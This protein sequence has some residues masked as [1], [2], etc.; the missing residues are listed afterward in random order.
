MP[1]SPFRSLKAALAVPAVLAI[2]VVILPAVAFAQKL[3]APAETNSSSSA[4]A[5]PATP[6]KTPATQGVIVVTD[7]PPDFLNQ[8]PVRAGQ[9]T[10][11]VIVVPPSSTFPVKQPVSSVAGVSVYGLNDVEALQKLKIAFG[12][13][14]QETVTLDDGEKRWTARREQLGL[15]IPYR[16]LLTK[17]RTGGNV[18]LRYEIDLETTR[19]TLLALVPQ[20]DGAKLAID[21]SALRVKAA[22]EATSSK[23]TI[24]LVVVRTSG[25]KKPEL[26]G[27]DSSGLEKYPYVLAEYSSRYDAGLR[28]RTNNLRMAAKLV[29]G[30]VVPDGGVFSTNKS[31]GPRNAKDG[32]REAQMFVSGQV[33]SG[34]GAG[35]CQCAS[36]IYNAALLAGLPIVERHPHMFRV[37]YVP[38][39]RDATI[40]WGSKDMRF[41]NNTGGPIYVQT[42][43][44]G[45]RFHARLLGTQ[46]RTGEFSVESRVISRKKGTLSE[47]YRIARSEDSVVKQKLS[48]DYYM[49]HP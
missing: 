26:A 45:G 31:I 17:A 42:Y 24:Q 13:K 40:Y 15:S 46:P 2:T 37:T 32:W 5:A 12:P 10:G 41:R 1:A 16:A 38:A 21:G 3:P 20:L 8:P 28:G 33:V 19:R 14:L 22:L 48:R 25:L 39:S 11:Q 44:K 35:I 47:A 7:T 6:T 30:T 4:P 27:G 49:P 43:L 36:S 34:V 23:S 9:G 18:P 29:N